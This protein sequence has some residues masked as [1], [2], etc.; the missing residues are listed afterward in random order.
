MTSDVISTKNS[1]SPGKSGG[2]L[3]SVNKERQNI[4]K[5]TPE[6]DLDTLCDITNFRKIV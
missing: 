6:D 4:F 3:R 5:N 2:G 1:E